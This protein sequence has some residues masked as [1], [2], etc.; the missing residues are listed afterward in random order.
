MLAETQWI[1]WLS[2]ITAENLK[3]VIFLVGATI[4]GAVWV[5]A[6]AWRN[7]RIA[8]YRTRLTGALL[9]RGMG[10][11]EVERILRATYEP[12]SSNEAKQKIKPGDSA[13]VRIVK[14]LA[15]CYYN[16]RD[17]DKVL[18]AARESGPIDEA[19]VEMVKS[20]A[21]NWVSADEIAQVIRSRSAREEAG[22]PGAGT[23]AHRP[24]VA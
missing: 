13:E 24:R 16:G 22:G 2:T 4:V 21:N 17:I 18:A 1:T 19:C 15:A 10:A 9:Q 3:E 5:A 11:D 14:R 23:A 20:M 8:E 7:T 6:S 12:K